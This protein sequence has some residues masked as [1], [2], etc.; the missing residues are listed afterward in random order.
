MTRVIL[1]PDFC[2]VQ[3]RHTGQ[4]VGNGPRHRD[5]LRL[6]ELD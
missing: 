5:S 4:L 1:D 2:Y 3:N 6:W